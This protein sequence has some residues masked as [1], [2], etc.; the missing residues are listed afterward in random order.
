MGKFKENALNELGEK[1][2]FFFLGPKNNWKN[3][4]KQENVEK[5]NLN[6]K[7]EME[8]LGYL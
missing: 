5:I 6:F 7:D 8:E 3:Y 2:Q 4:L 1:K